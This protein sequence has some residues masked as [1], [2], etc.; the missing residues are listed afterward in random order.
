MAEVIAQFEITEETQKQIMDVLVGLLT[1]LHLN[2]VKT[3]IAVPAAMM[4]SAQL[5]A[6]GS[7]NDEEYIVNEFRK[8]IKQARE[9]PLIEIV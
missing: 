2:K 6:H 1:T 4:L 9:N 5:V 7:L 3:E 8:Q